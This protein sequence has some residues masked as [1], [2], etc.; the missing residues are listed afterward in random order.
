MI[1][2]TMIGFALGPIFAGYIYDVTQSYSTAL[3]IFLIAY[4]V[5]LLAIYFAW[6]AKP[7]ST[8]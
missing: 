1:F 5:S 2:I 4:I 8:V 6:G 7:K 3:S